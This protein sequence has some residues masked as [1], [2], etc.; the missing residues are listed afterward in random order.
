[1]RVLRIAWRPIKNF[2]DRCCKEYEKEVI[3]RE[4]PEYKHDYPRAKI[5]GESRFFKGFITAVVVF[6]IIFITY[7]PSSMSLVSC[8]ESIEKILNNPNGF[9][10]RHRRPTTPKWTLWGVIELETSS[11][12]CWGLKAK[13]FSNM[14]NLNRAHSKIMLRRC[15][16]GDPGQWYHAEHSFGSRTTWMEIGHKEERG[17]MCVI[18]KSPKGRDLTWGPCRVYEETERIE[19]QRVEDDGEEKEFSW[20]SLNRLPV[21]KDG[22]PIEFEDENEAKAHPF[23]KFFLVTREHLTSKLW[24]YAGA[25]PEARGLE[26]RHLLAVEPD[27]ENRDIDTQGSRPRFINVNATSAEDKTSTRPQHLHDPPRRLA[28]GDDEGENGVRIGPRGTD[29]DDENKDKEESTK[30]S[31]GRDAWEDA[32]E[33]A[34]AIFNASDE[35][36]KEE[37]SPSFDENGSTTTE[38]YDE[39]D[40]GDGEESGRD[41]PK[42]VEIGKITQ[43]Q[44]HY[45]REMRRALPSGFGYTIKAHNQQPKVEDGIDELCSRS[46]NGLIEI[47]PMLEVAFLIIYIID[48][49]IAFLRRGWIWFFESRTHPITVLTAVGVLF[50]VLDVNPFGMGTMRHFIMVRLITV[51]PFVLQLEHHFGSFRTPKLYCESFFIIYFPTVG[52]IF[53]FI[54]YAAMLFTIFMKDRLLLSRGLEAS[55]IDAL[56]GNLFP[57]SF[58]S[59]MQLFTLDKWFHVIQPLAVEFFITPMPLLVLLIVGTFFFVMIA[60]VFVTSLLFFVSRIQAQVECEYEV[61]RLKQK[62]RMIG[63]LE[64]TLAASKDD[65]ADK[66]T[67]ITEK[68]MVRRCSRKRAKDYLTEFLG[69]PLDQVPTIFQWFLALKPCDP[70]TR[71]QALTLSAQE[72][73]YGLQSLERKVTRLEYFRA[74]NVLE[75]NIELLKEGQKKAA[76]ITTKIQQQRTD[77]VNASADLDA[78]AFRIRNILNRAVDE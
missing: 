41:F 68:K 23:K 62:N 50:T 2:Y 38:T 52:I 60:H 75:H 70:V 18:P 9:M 76:D 63:E 27:A 49:V 57:E 20:W 43:V 13:T 47:Y 67:P 77:F 26:H 24:L 37:S 61:L 66:N 8:D 51:I 1:M 71:R 53:F 5:I 21:D 65:I 39:N 6:H 11:G 7:C 40:V 15:N 78:I 58:V 12:L 46:P 45:E 48:I 72:F 34:S 28:E 4:R 44:L 31:S 55:V 69:L 17:R 3:Q 32:N 54:L 19:G 25:H 56:F 14:A 42:D 10:I 22:N 59:A 36:E 16:P 74:S 35:D 33:L 30:P 64:V 29:A 73:S